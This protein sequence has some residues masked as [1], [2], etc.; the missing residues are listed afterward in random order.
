MKMPEWIAKT[1][2]Q[3]IQSHRAR[4]RL[5]ALGQF[6]DISV[7]FHGKSVFLRGTDFCLTI[8]QSIYALR[9]IQVFEVSGDQKLTKLG[10]RLPSEVLPE[11]LLWTPIA[12][13]ISLGL[14]ETIQTTREEC[15]SKT[16]LRIVPLSEIDLPPSFEFPIAQ[17]LMTTA[18]RWAQ[19]ARCCPEFRLKCLR[20]AADIS[21]NVLIQGNPLPSLVGEFFYQDGQLVLP[22]GMTWSPHVSTGIVKKVYRIPDQHLLLLR[23]DAGPMIISQGSFVA[24]SRIAAHET[25]AAAGRSDQEIE[26]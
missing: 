21:G 4:Q 20:F 23:P 11:D 5:A 9:N 3:S 12:K 18:E 24:A 6:T 16:E 15:A 19:Y 22:A 14:P 17:F 2:K 7:A 8:G 25:F 10:K 13:V 1:D 26:E